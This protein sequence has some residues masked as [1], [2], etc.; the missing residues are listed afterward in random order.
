MEVVDMRRG[1][2]AKTGVAPNLS[3]LDDGFSITLHRTLLF[4][5]VCCIRSLFTCL[6]SVLND[7]S[8]EGLPPPS[9]QLR[10][11]LLHEFTHGLCDCC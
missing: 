10:I 2:C 6:P 8:H 7:T 4:L 9:H 11:T 1:G 5:L 3:R